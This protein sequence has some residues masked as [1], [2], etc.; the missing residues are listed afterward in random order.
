LT[1]AKNLSHRSSI[2]V[3]SGCAGELHEEPVQT[4]GH[5]DVATTRKYVHYA[6]Q[7]DAAKCLGTL[8]DEQLGQVVPLRPAA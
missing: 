3:S 7:P 4:L 2:V 1:E 5:A 8:I 6:P